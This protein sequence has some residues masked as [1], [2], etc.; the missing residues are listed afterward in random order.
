MFWLWF[1]DFARPFF[2]DW[3]NVVKI[4]GLMTLIGFLL[5]QI[6]PVG[7]RVPVSAMLF[8]LAY[9]AFSFAVLVT[10]VPWLQA[11][12][13]PIVQR[14]GGLVHLRFP[15]GLFGS[16]LSVGVF[17]LIYDFFY[18]W[19]HRAQHATPWLWA[20]HEL[21]HAERHVNV[22]TSAR[23]HW[24]EE[25]IRVF[26]VLLPMSLLF[27]L[28]GPSVSAVFTLAMFFGYFI[29]LNLRLELGL[30]TSVFGGPQYHRLH[31][32]IE[33]QHH[34]LNFAALFP[35]WDRLFGTQRLPMSGEWPETGLTDRPRANSWRHALFGPFIAWASAIRVFLL[36][37]S[38]SRRGRRFGPTVV[39]SPQD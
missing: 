15:D 39:D 13:N 23:H 37:Q 24:L 38:K 25:S 3:L 12:T 6:R 27:R 14:W 26:V 28:D 9:V 19:W 16:L 34:N 4:A 7:K 22:T 18:Y 20:V 8:N 36:A 31:H 21:H 29:H 35:I 17:L 33:S 11:Y 10:L 30:F 1:E 2:A 32:S 5:E